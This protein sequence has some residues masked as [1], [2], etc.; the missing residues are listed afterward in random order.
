MVQMTIRHTWFRVSEYVTAQVPVVVPAKAPPVATMK[1][2]KRAMV[3]S[4]IFIFIFLFFLAL[5]L[6]LVDLAFF[7]IYS[8]L[9]FD[10]G[11]GLG[12]DQRE[13]CRD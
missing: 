12:R 1:S 7:L 9:L 8:L 3:K 11:L 13:D 6:G 2:P 5:F 10:A 4:F